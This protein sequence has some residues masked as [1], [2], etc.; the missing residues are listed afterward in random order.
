MGY[1]PFVRRRMRPSGFRLTVRWGKVYTIDAVEICQPDSDAQLVARELLSRASAMAKRELEDGE[2]RL[3]WTRHAAE[4]G[5]KTVRGACVAY[6]VRR[7]RAEAEI[8]AA[9]LRS[10]A[11][12]RRAR[13]EAQRQEAMDE[14][15][16]ECM[17]R[18]MGGRS[19]V[20]AH[21]AAVYGQV[22]V[23]GERRG[24]RRR[25]VRVVP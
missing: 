3:Y 19:D 10:A 25:R 2:R 16:E 21:R 11:A 1:L 6:W 7:L 12:E 15:V 13:R 9:A 23:R 5:Y 20:Q 18:M 8:E 17:R 4:L 14:S 24:A 22:R